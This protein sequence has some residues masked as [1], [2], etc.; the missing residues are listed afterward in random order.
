METHLPA[1]SRISNQ[2][3]F[4]HRC[5]AAILSATLEDTDIVTENDTSHVIVTS[6]VN[7]KIKL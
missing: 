5:M 7:N 2:W 1:V 3:E 4:S 6:K